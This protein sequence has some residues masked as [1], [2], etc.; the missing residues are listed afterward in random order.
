MFRPARRLPLAVMVGA[1][2]GLG[3]LLAGCAR[4]GPPPAGVLA[5]VNGQPVRAAEL[6]QL[7]A[8]QT[9]GASTPLP[10]DQSLQ[11]RLS[12]LN[13]LIDRHILLQYGAQ[14]GIKPDPTALARALALARTRQPPLPPEEARQQASDTL[15]LNALLQREV[16][17]RVHVDDHAI[18]AFYQ[19]NQASFNLP[20]RQYHVL[21]IVVTPSPG[22]VTNLAQDKAA[23]PAAAQKKI[24]MLEQRLAQHADFATLAQQYSEDSSTASSG[25]DLGLIPQSVLMTQ[26]P[27]A[28]REAILRLQ[29]GQVSQ[30]ISTPNGYYLLKLVGIE[31]A[32]LRPLSDPQVRQSIRDLLSSARQ[33]LLQAAFL[34]TVRNQ[35]KVV[36]YLAQQILEQK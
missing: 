27:A 7:Y 13:Q 18:A 34:A 11:L 25:G 4:P 32:G 19:Q 21:E 31:P 36:N 9:A 6:D 30:P 15:V 33:R 12:L 23:T 22:P 2:L 5:T 28:L 26:T 17:D 8:A 1:G 35:A 16:S 14:L 29:P 24:G 20:E 3:T 10:A